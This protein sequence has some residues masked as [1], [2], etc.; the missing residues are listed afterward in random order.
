M[1]LQPKGNHQTVSSLARRI[2]IRPLK[3]RK[4]AR[5]PVLHPT[6]GNPIDWR[7]SRR[8]GQLAYFATRT[9]IADIVVGTKHPTLQPIIDILAEDAGRRAAA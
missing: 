5:L 8:K 4:A 2:Q 1:N 3:K 7:Y 9:G 6:T